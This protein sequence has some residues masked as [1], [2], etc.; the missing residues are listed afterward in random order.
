MFSGIKSREGE[1][2]IK[3]KQG[4][5]VYLVQENEDRISKRRS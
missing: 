5:H 1:I 4:I 2:P 3:K